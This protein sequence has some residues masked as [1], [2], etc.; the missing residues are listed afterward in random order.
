[1]K[2][3]HR[4]TLA[5]F[6]FC[7]FSSLLY[8]QKPNIGI[9]GGYL[10]STQNNIGGDASARSV[11]SGFYLGAYADI[12]LSESFELSPE[13]DF[14]FLDGSNFG[15][16]VLKAKYYPVQNLYIQAGPQLSYIL[17]KVNNNFNKLGVDMVMGLGYDI[18]DKLHVQARYAPQL[19]KRN[20]ITEAE[21]IRFNWLQIGIGYKFL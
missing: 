7:T 6:L 5:I 10:N 17:E 14:A 12:A 3:L 18:T 1:M 11:L 20:K 2:F 16:L 8:S 19:T 21:N 4:N 9:V 15:Y 13:L